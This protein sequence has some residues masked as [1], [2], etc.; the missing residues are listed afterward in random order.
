MTTDE[1]LQALR[2]R[3]WRGSQDYD[4]LRLARLVVAYTPLEDGKL[5]A[6]ALRSERALDFTPLFEEAIRR[7]D[8][9]E[10]VEFELAG[11]DIDWTDYDPR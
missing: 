9:N 11:A 6:V 5:K 2:E 4:V 10:W 3:G 7:V 8:A 1:Y